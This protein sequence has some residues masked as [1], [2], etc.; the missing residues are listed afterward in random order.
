MYHEVL[1]IVC[2]ATF[3]VKCKENDLHRKYRLLRGPAKNV[4]SIISQIEQ[5]LWLYFIYKALD[6]SVTGGIFRNFWKIN[7]RKIFLKNVPHL[8]HFYAYFIK[9][10]IF[11]TGNRWKTKKI[12]L[13]GSRA[14]SSLQ[15]DVCFNHLGQ[16]LWEKIYFL[17]KKCNFS[18]EG[19]NT[20]KQQ[21]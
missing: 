3:S 11:F 5:N 10:C 1:H 8:S 15:N 14:F 9:F 20:S 4:S 13:L 18:G 2:F 12:Q 16:K 19:K 7:F 6:Q 17:Q 21:Y